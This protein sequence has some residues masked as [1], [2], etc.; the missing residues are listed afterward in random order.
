M[1]EIWTVKIVF[2]LVMAVRE[3][4]D[5]NGIGSD[6]IKMSSLRIFFSA[7]LV[8]GSLNQVVHVTI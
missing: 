6:I 7:I 2:I 1:L 5:N 8:Y 4:A 3:E